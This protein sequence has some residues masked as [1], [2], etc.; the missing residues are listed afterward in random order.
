MGAAKQTAAATLRA[1]GER[2][3][4][5]RARQRVAL[6][7]PLEVRL[8][9]RGER[10]LTS[11]RHGLARGEATPGERARGG[12]PRR[13]RESVARPAVPPLSRPPSPPDPPVKAWEA[14]VHPRGV[15]RS[16]ARLRPNAIFRCSGR[17][18]GERA[19]HGRDRRELCSPHDSAPHRCAP[20]R[21]AC[22][23]PP[24]GR[25]PKRSSPTM[26]VAMETR[27]GPI[28]GVGCSRRNG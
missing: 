7:W 13:P 6:H 20:R 4:A 12:K 18:F 15:G 2:R 17:R 8:L 10:A 3:P 27:S 5:K 9:S 1:G 25:S 14:L 28:A 21:R 16:L 23:G 11:L 26:V 22:D 24:C 19:R